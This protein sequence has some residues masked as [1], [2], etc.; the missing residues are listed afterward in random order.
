MLNNNDVDITIY[1]VVDVQNVLN[2]L[3]I[4]VNIEDFL[5][6]NNIA[7]TDVVGVGILSGGDVVVFSQG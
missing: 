5:N 7:L 2:D 6:N 3:V 4:D 1:D